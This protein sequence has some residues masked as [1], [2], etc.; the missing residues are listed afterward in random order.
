M[1]VDRSDRKYA[2]FKDLKIFTCYKH[3]NV[4]KKRLKKVR[5]TSTGA[6][7][8]EVSS[9]IGP[10]SVHSVDG[11]VILNHDDEMFFM[12]GNMFGSCLQKLADSYSDPQEYKFLIA[13]VLQVD[14]DKVEDVEGARGR[15]FRVGTVEGSNVI[16]GVDSETWRIDRSTYSQQRGLSE[17]EGKNLGEASVEEVVQLN[18]LL[19]MLITS[20]LS[21]DWIRRKNCN[22][23]DDHLVGKVMA[24]STLIGYVVQ[25]IPRPL[26]SKYSS[27]A[28][29]DRISPY[30]IKKSRQIS[31]YSID[32][33]FVFYY[34]AFPAQGSLGNP[35][36]LEMLC[37]GN[38][39]GWSTLKD[40]DGE[41][42]IE[43]YIEQPI[44]SMTDVIDSTYSKVI[45]SVDTL[46]G[47]ANFIYG[48]GL[49]LNP[50]LHAYLPK[51]ID[52]SVPKKWPKRYILEY[53]HDVLFDLDIEYVEEGRLLINDTDFSL[54]A[55]SKRS[56]FNNVLLN[57]KGSLVFPYTMDYEIEPE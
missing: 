40:K 25:P 43:K 41:M 46:T 19:S 54:V 3:L 7:V 17:Q 18:R 26:S 13:D 42:G 12:S 47:R 23:V 24:I 8:Y 32:N 35:P 30:R 53:I 28:I 56:E 34:F 39:N 57:I 29:L 1:T 6:V 20:N 16:V 52:R 22:P 45:V 55:K 31:G 9:N 44:P 36:V 2:S 38:R 37:D 10:S 48:S 21:Q 27:R 15:E 11:R 33:E 4:E 14:D 49:T 51:D 5:T 50:N